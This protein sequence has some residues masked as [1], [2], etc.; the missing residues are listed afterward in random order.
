MNFLEKLDNKIL[1]FFTKISHKFQLL[2]GRTN[3]FL[4]N[5]CLTAL[6]LNAVLKI[7]NYLFPILIMRTS[8]LDLLVMFLF[9][10]LISND[11]QKLKKADETAFDSN[12]AHSKT[13][14]DL[15]SNCAWRLIFL[16]T[17]ILTLP[18]MCLIAVGVEPVKT[19][20]LFEIIGDSFAI[21]ITCYFYFTEVIPLPPGKSKVREWLES[22]DKVLVPIPI[23][24]KN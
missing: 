23:R 13:R 14:F 7:I 3:F 17:A 5:I 15:N 19:G 12:G 11:K 2:T 20:R 9:V 24:N 4:A 1:S 16:V 22:F 8:G 18:V 21:T 6:A 10:Y